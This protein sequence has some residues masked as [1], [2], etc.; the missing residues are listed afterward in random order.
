ME[1]IVK[2]ILEEAGW[3]PNRK[4]EIGE[5]TQEY[6]NYGLNPPDS[7]LQNLLQEYWNLRLYFTMPDGQE[8]DIRLNTD[9][10]RNVDS[11]SLKIF[12][13]ILTDTLVPV[14]SIYDDTALLIASYSGKFY[15]LSNKLF[16]ILGDNFHDALNTI[17]NQKDLFRIN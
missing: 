12:D 1:N 13:D 14:G 5:M 15:M 16:F 6:K 4:I 3:Y 9:V 10:I 2:N 8:N 17:I 11:K 7:N